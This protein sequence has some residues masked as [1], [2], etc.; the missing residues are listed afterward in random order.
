MNLTCLWLLRFTTLL[1]NPKGPAE[2]GNPN[3]CAEA[4]PCLFLF[5]SALRRNSLPRE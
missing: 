5:I 2:P 1:G 3:N 4:K